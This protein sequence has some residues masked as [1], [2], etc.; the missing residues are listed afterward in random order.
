ML[1]QDIKNIYLIAICGTGMASLAGLL[2]ESGYHVTGSDSNIYPPMS[3]LLAD[4]GIPVKAGYKADNI[5]ASEIDLVIVGNAVSKTNEEVQAVLAAGIPHT[6]FPDALAR[7]YLEGRKSLVVA[8]THGKTTTTALLAWVL[9]ATRK[10]PGFMVGGWLK[11]FDK[12]FRGP[13]ADYFVIEGD[14][15]DTAFFDKGAKFLH[16]RPFAVILTGV[17]FDHADIF[18]NLDTI[19]A[20][21]RKFVALIP[22]AGFL[23]VKFADSHAADVLGE[24]TCAVETYSLSTGADWCAKNYRFEDGFGR[25]TLVHKGSAQCEVKLPMIGRHNAENAVAVAALAIKLGIP[26]GE[27][28]EA[29]A[30]FKGIRRRQDVVGEKNGVIV[31]DDF[32]HHPTAIALTIN[33]VKEAYPDCTVW[34]VFEPRSATSRRNTFQNDFP[35]SF[36]EADRVVIAGLYSPDS[37]PP[38]DRLDP[39]KV[40]SDIRALGGQADY[41]PEV[42]AIIK[43]IVKNNRGHDVV[44]VMSSGGFSGIH[45]KLLEAL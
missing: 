15:Y 42:T 36:I 41:L 27:V 7:F 40:V 25:F 6:S 26:A 10:D 30:G 23:L 29:F 38:E 35:A 22:P 4:A 37:I 12:N 1:P 11:N 43:Y 14:E 45:Q 34:A 2:K 13:G 8:G 21:F 24:A 17:E 44:L 3:H 19:K 18:D 9:Q 39:E 31:V 16:Y 28:G 33:A 20:S 5:S 32:A